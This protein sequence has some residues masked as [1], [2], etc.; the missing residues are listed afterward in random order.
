VTA[1]GPRCPRSAVA[2]R[3][4]SV[5]RRG[6]PANTAVNKTLFNPQQRPAQPTSMPQLPL[7]SRCSAPS[8]PNRESFISHM[9]AYR[10]ERRLSRPHNCNPTL[11]PSLSTHS[12]PALSATI[13]AAS[14]A[15]LASVSSFFRGTLL[16]I[17]FA[18][19]SQDRPLFE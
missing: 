4:A 6:G 10:C 19:I 11:S 5:R 12:S 13:P 18:D 17:R 2:G 7:Q 8:I 9:Y 3:C 1:R 16:H 15:P 14:N